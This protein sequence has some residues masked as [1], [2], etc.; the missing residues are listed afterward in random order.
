MHTGLE[1][2][3]IFINIIVYSIFK[4]KIEST[5]CLYLYFGVKNKNKL[6]IQKIINKRIIFT[7][8]SWSS[9]SVPWLLQPMVEGGGS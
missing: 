6:K 7:Q 3:N 8:S 4:R 2:R 5:C 1:V 9:S